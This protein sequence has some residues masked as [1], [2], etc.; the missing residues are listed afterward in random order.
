MTRSRYELDGRVVLLTGGARGI[1]ADA[2]RRLHSRG[3]RAMLIDRDAPEVEA[4]AAEL[5]DRAPALPVDVTDAA[6]REA[7]VAE[8]LQRFG[9]IDVVIANAGIRGAPCT[10]ETVDPADFERVIEV[11][12]L[13]VWRTIRAVLRHVIERR[14]YLLPIASVAAA[15]P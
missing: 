6:G 14:G 5:G 12:L 9:A 2:A 15:V 4:R 13:G 3:A 11:N 7:A 10:L 1:G 8:T